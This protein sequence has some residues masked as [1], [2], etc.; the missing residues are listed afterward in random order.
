MF[1]VNSLPR[2]PKPS[3]LFSKFAPLVEIG[4]AMTLVWMMLPSTLRYVAAA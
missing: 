3:S 4:L 1:V 2:T